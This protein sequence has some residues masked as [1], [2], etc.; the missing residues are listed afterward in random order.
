MIDIID[1]NGAWT[2]TWQDGERGPGKADGVMTA[3]GTRPPQ[4]FSA[5]VPGEVHLDLMAAGIL[6]EPTVG[7]NCLKSRWVEECYWI[8]RR[9]FTLGTLEAGA[10]AFLRFDRLELSAV[11]RLNGVEVG[12]HANAFLPACFEVTGALRS[13]ENLL[14]VEIEAGLFGACDRP[15]EGWGANDGVRLTK[16]HWLRTVQSSA[17]WDWSQ[18]LLNVGITGGVRLEVCRG[19]RVDDSSVI[20]ELDESLE[21]GTIRGRVFLENLDASPRPAQMSLD[22]RLGASDV[23][24]EARYL[25]MAPGAQRLQIET[26]LPRPRLWWPRGQGEQ[27]LYE[28]RLT[29]SVGETIVL[30]QRR[31]VG[32]RRVRVNQEKVADGRLFCLEV[33]GRQV[34]CKGG[35]FVPADPIPARIS[36]ARY[37]T[38]VERAVEA[39]FTM[40]RVWGGG[41]YERDDSWNRFA[42]RRL[43]RPAGWLI[44]RAWW[45]GAE[46]TSWN[47]ETGPGAMW[48]SAP[49]HRTTTSSTRSFPGSCGRRT[50]PATISPARPTLRITT[51]PTATTAETST[52]G[53]SGSRTTTSA[54]TGP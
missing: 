6:E 22:V 33:N 17:G 26:R 27:V 21:A 34:F 8:Y 5:R 3:A 12:R 51:T 16:R 4:S 24:H 19:I 39:N 18:R 29:L 9:P 1:L 40:L 36:G 35:D 48:R 11:A 52:P 45:S 20:C 10:R 32:F 46:T 7:L 37:R 54:R 43:I 49:R 53:P 23:L 13:G 41:L 14:V 42:P 50:E 38:L 15:W 44:I 25:T 47:G 31:M 2:L 28:V 30:D